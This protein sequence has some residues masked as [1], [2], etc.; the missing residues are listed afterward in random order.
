MTLSE[1]REVGER[2]ER[3]VITTS[4]F[5]FLERPQVRVGGVG[6]SVT[7]LPEAVQEFIQAAASSTPRGFAVRLANAYCVALAAGEPFYSTVLNG[8]GVT[9]PD[10]A[11]IAW[12]V[13]RKTRRS[14]VC[15]SRV[16]GPSFF[17]D[18]LDQGR[19]AGL[20]HYILG[21][22][23]ETLAALTAEVDR[24]FPGVQIAGTWA[25]PYGP[26]DA[27]FYD[28]AAERIHAAEA[29]VLWLGLG[30]PKQDLAAAVLSARLDL[31]TVGVGAAFDFF[32]GSV[33]EAPP[34]L[35]DH[36]LEWL[37]RL[38]TEPRR[39]W[40]RYLFGNLRFLAAVIADELRPLPLR[41]G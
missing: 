8:P 20:R 10:G 23:Q 34:L 15:G 19:A 35:R 29:D 13:Q 5:A 7:T 24:Q 40:R 12:M 33:P 36:G 38:C 1:S 9:L 2:A 4:D 22:S 3:P 11:P 16:R 28:E 27:A 39:L 18:V 26:L 21:A 6:F 17:V 25:P 32:A 30:T 41:R 37:Y 31:P 14:L